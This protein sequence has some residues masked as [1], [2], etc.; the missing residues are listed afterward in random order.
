MPLAMDAMM[1]PVAVPTTA[2]RHLGAVP[3]ILGAALLIDLIL[4]AALPIDL[5]S[6]VVAQLSFKAS[7]V[8]PVA[9]M[10]T[11]PTLAF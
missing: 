6:R 1:P 3:L 9:R 8:M 7:A 10:G 5:R 4:V 11:R 2:P